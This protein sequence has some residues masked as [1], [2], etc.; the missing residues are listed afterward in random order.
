MEEV[1]YLITESKFNEIVSH[2]NAAL[3]AKVEYNTDTLKMAE[4]TIETM[5]THMKLAK[6]TL[7][8]IEDG[9]CCRG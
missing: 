9:D 2:I 5:R 6:N 3:H 4:G 7:K 1:S 8:R